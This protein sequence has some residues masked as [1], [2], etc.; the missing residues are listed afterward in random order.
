MGEFTEN[1]SLFMPDESDSMAD[2][3]TNLTENFQKI[4]PRG[5]PTIIAADGALPQVGNYEVG[6]R[7]FRNDP[8]G[9][10]D[11]VHWPSSYLLVAKD[12]NW[13]WHWRP[14]Q[15]ILSPWVTV[16]A[17]AFADANYEQHATTPL[18][19][20][21]DYRGW[22]RW[23]GRIQKT[24][25]GI[26]A[27]TSISVFK[28]LPEGI[29]PN[30]DV[31]HTVALSPITGTATGKPGNISGRIFIAQSGASSIRCFNSNNGVSQSI[32]FSGLK[33]N[34]SAHWYFSG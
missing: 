33:Y 26:P 5:D 25:A 10:V 28:T 34:N 8:V 3:V 1:Y 27:A 19:I 17:T 4:E 31:M 6:D 13:G 23:R 32:W 12:A 29:R 24:A 7:V 16:P 20:A 18:Q 2:V 21:L 11:G 30:V 22:C 9:G 15:Q 14:I